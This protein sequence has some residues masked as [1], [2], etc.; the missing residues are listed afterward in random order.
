MPS[1]S[2]GLVNQRQKVATVSAQNTH[3]LQLSP[4]F[5]IKNVK[6]HGISPAIGVR[7]NSQKYTPAKLYPQY[8]LAYRC[9]PNY[10]PF[11]GDWC[12]EM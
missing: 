5:P 12:V 3:P 4:E 10:T 11:M 8:V 7:Y 9:T 6:K 2:L 1:L